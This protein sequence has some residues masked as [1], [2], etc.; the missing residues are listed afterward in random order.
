MPMV[1]HE[2]EDDERCCRPEY[3]KKRRCAKRKLVG[4]LKGVLRVVVMLLPVPMFWALF[5]QQKTLPDAP[6]SN[7][8]FV[9]VINAFPDSSCNFDLNIDEFGTRRIVANHS[10][11]DD[12][13]RDITDVIRIEHEPS[14]R[15]KFSFVSTSSNCPTHFEI[16]PHFEGGKSYLIVLAPGGWAILTNDWKKPQKGRGQFALSTLTISVDWVW[17][18]NSNA[19]L[20]SRGCMDVCNSPNH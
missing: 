19:R 4:D 7:E 13:D 20:S 16:E 15:R 12:K 18:G 2:C 10:L 9:S 8:A 3:R 11:M 14:L 17:L 5:E 1:D 6:R